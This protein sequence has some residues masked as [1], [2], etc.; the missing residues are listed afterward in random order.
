ML[1]CLQSD[2]VVF[3]VKINVFG[4]NMFFFYLFGIDHVGFQR[5]IIKVVNYIFASF[6][7]SF[8]VKKI[9]YIII[10]NMIIKNSKK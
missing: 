5:Q 2:F 3:Y 4:R 8:N 10:V 7:G 9:M 1:L 6:S